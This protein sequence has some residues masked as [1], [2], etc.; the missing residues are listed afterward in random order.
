MGEFFYTVGLMAV[1]GGIIYCYEKWKN[2][3]PSQGRGLTGIAQDYF[4]KISYLTQSLTEEKRK[5]IL[6]QAYHII[7]QYQKDYSPQQ[8]IKILHILFNDKYKDSV[9]VE[10][11]AISLIL[12]D[13]LRSYGPD[14]LGR[15]MAIAYYDDLKQQLGELYD[16]C[17]VNNKYF[18]GEI[19]DCFCSDGY[20]ILKEHSKYFAKERESQSN[21]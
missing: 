7:T 6:E 4:L 21:K 13:R 15:K 3:G 20:Y 9:R 14:E 2:A 10:C 1:F 11:F 12:C 5:Y 19:V 18:P 8:D 17:V 16:F